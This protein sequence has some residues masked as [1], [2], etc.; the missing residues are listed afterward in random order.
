MLKRVAGAVPLPEHTRNTYL[1][2]M[3]LHTPIPLSASFGIGPV[4]ASVRPVV[5]RREGD[6][7]VLPIEGIFEIV[8]EDSRSAWSTRLMEA[9]ELKLGPG[10]TLVGGLDRERGLY[11]GLRADRIRRL[12]DPESGTRL[13]AGVLDWL[14]ERAERQKRERAARDRAARAGR[15][16]RA[17]PRRKE[18]A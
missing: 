8:Y 14:L 7:H 2:F 13:E 11:R 12:V 3:N 16:D 5:E 17:A 6:W 18:A 9:R 1:V 15:R 4:G 10:R